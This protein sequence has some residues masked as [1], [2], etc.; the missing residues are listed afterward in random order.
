MPEDV[1]APKDGGEAFL[2]GFEWGE[3]PFGMGTADHFRWCLEWTAA[4]ADEP[5]VA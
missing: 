4:Q 2:E 1:R 3:N 5:E